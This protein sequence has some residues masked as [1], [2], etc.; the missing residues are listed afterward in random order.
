LNLAV[1][2]LS[3]AK[4]FEVRAIAHNLLDR[5]YEDPS[6]AYGVPGDYPRA[7]LSVFIDAKYRF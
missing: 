6:P 1:R 5:G 7:G 4:N 3:F 2:R